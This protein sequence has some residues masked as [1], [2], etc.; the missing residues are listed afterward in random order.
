MAVFNGAGKRERKALLD[1]FDRLAATP[2]MESD[3]TIDDSTAR[4]HY[5]LAVGHYLVTY[6]SDHAAREVRI[7]KSNIDQLTKL[8]WRQDQMLTNHVRDENV[9]RV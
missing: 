8:I 6:W 7:V 4:T 1:F 9:R 5:R 2:F 3:W